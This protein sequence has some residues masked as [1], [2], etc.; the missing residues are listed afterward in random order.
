MLFNSFIFLF[1]FLPVALLSHWLVER[2]RPEWR[3]P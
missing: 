3:L 1:G 2:F